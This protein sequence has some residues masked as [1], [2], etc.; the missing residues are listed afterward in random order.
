MRV[1]R[2][3]YV[4]DTGG[5]GEHRGGLSLEREY[6]FLG[7][8]MLS[9]APTGATILPYGIGGGRARDAVRER[10]WRRRTAR[11]ARMPSKFSRPVSAGDRFDHRTAGA[12][13]W[14]DALRREPE[15]VA[16]DVRNGILLGRALAAYGVVVTAEGVIDRGDRAERDR[17]EPTDAP[18]PTPAT[19]LD[20][21]TR[22]P[23]DLDVL[24]RGGRVIDGLGGPSVVADVAHR[25]R[26]GRGDRGASSGA[27]ARHAWSTPAGSSSRP[28]S[29]TSTATATSRS[30]P[31]RAHAARSP[32]A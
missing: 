5:V 31:I 14:G 23:D 2:Y 9:S 20:A 30:S 8:A 1:D 12:G 19:P 16:A 15:A 3:G 25:R 11:S 29:S 26:S 13:G 6:T 28:G 27:E 22:S 10:C 32:R 21:R 17:V 4:P 24:I 7:E 18:P